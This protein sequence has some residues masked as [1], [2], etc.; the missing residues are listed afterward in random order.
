M[1]RD[2]LKMQ[3]LEIPDLTFRNVKYGKAETE[4]DLRPLLYLGG[5]AA[6]SN[7]VANQIEE[8]F[9]CS[10]IE[11]RIPLVEKLHEYIDARLAGG[12]SRGTA[13]LTI[14][15]LR[16]FFSWADGEGRA[17]DLTSAESI[18][19]GWTDHLLYRV[20]VLRD[21][22]EIHAYQIAVAI[23]KILDCA[24]DLRK[25]LLSKTRLRRPTRN[26][27]ALGTKADKQ[28]LEQT[29]AFGHALSDIADSLSVNAIRGKLPV[30]ITFRSGHVHEEWLKLK[31]PER[32]KTLDMNTRRSTRNK[33]IETRRAYEED[34][35]AR[36]RFPLINLRIEAEMLIFI[37]QTGMNLEQ[38]HTLKM[39]KFRYSSH[40]DGYRV[41]RVYKARRQGEV[42]FEIFSEYRDVFERYLAWRAAMFLDHES[43]LLFPLLSAGRSLE[44]SPH[45]SAVMSMCKRLDLRFF[46]PQALRKTRINWLLR[47]SRDPSITADM[48][49]HTQET[50]LKSYEQPSFQV[51]L[52]EISLF[53]QR[54]D[55]AIASPGPGLCVKESAGPVTLPTAPPEA[56]TPDCISP[57]GCLFCAYQRDIDT[58][59]HVWSLAS[60]RYLKSL[61]LIR[62]RPAA[63]SNMPHPAKAAMDRLTAKLSNFSK[64]SEVRSLWVHEALS[65]IE[66]ENYH[67]RWDGFIQLMETRK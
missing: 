12:G 67:P 46:G 18:F 59:D 63:K 34:I 49:A 37:A 43:E 23:A 8:G 4:W 58:E 44:V 41:H 27:P 33:T 54:S 60:Y 50:L 64:S 42:A 30:R 36:T 2:I 62:Y 32:A 28:N 65:R 7:L 13:G 3:T 66:E 48:H 39:S 15:R 61:E 35:S 55:P 57:A 52:S 45:L 6:R 29:F 51:A 38:V 26:S 19:I 47:H 5:A 20:R 24:L 40:L 16:Q 31:P 11:E 22:K 56:T 9:F 14:I 17:I 25:G 10:P 21:I 1:V 53:H